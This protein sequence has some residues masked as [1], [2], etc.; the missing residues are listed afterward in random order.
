MAG[1]FDEDKGKKKNSTDFAQ[2]MKSQYYLLINLSFGLEFKNS[3][4]KTGKA[5][6]KNAFLKRFYE[7][8]LT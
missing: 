6:R 2:I 1:D 8:I 3:N 4:P 5:I 7:C